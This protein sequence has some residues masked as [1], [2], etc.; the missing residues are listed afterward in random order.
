MSEHSS[1]PD[2]FQNDANQLNEV[3]PDPLSVILEIANLV[4]QPGTLALIGNIASGAGAVAAA[5]IAYKQVTN[6]KKSEIRCKLFETDRALTKGFAGLT[7]LASLLNEFNYIE[8][9]MLVGGSAHKR[10]QQCTGVA[11][12]PR[13]L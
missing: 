6:Q 3:D 7:T 8:R 2:G 13:G 9:R 12:S 4:F 10:L 5:I 11:S 1:E